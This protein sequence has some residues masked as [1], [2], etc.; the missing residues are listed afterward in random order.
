VTGEGIASAEIGGEVPD[1]PGRPTLPEGVGEVDAATEDNFE[2][3][4]GIE[5]DHPVVGYRKLVK[6]IRGGGV[7]SADEVGGVADGA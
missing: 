7:G 4:A 3:G 2:V 5:T 6:L 1:F